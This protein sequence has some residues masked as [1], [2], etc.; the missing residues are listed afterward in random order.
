MPETAEPITRDRAS[1]RAAR[2]LLPAGAAALA[3]W[4]FPQKPLVASLWVLAAGAAAALWGRRELGRR[5]ALARSGALRQESIEDLCGV[6][7]WEW[8]LPG[9]RLRLSAEASR[10]L[11]GGAASESFPGLLALLPEEE[12]ETLSAAV[13]RALSGADRF[14]VQ[15]A[16]IPS[17]GVRR[18]I[19]HSGA[20]FRDAAGEPERLIG[21]LQDVTGRE[22][23]EGALFFE[24]RYRALIENLPQRIFLKDLNSVYLSCNSSFARDLGLEPAQVF[25]RTDHDLFPPQLAQK[26]LQDDARVLAAGVPE[27]RDELRERD[28]AWISKALIPLKDD[29]GRTYGLLGILTDVTSRKQA[30]EQLKESE[31]RFRNTFEQA[32]VGICHLTLK[33]G[34]IRINRRF[35]EILG[36]SQEELLGRVLD[37][38]IHPEDLAPEH[39]N[40]ERLLNREIDSYSME[41]RHLKKEGAPVWVNFSMSLV[42]NRAGEPRYFAAMIEDI[43]A[44]REAEAL[45][46]ERDLVQASSRAMSQLLANMSHEIRTPMNAVLGLGHLALKTELTPKQRDY[47]EKICSSSRNLLEI[48]NDILDFSKI[49]S[50]RIELEWTEFNLS[51]V[52]KTVSD[53]MAPRA[54]EKGI[55]YRVRVAPELPALVTGDPLRLAQVLNNLIANAV[56]FTEK[57]EVLVEVRPAGWQ[58]D[59]VA[60]RFS[61]QDTGVGLTPEQLE[62]IFTPFTQ[63][64]SSTT[65]RYGGTGLGLSI[66]SQL[67]ELMGGGLGVE[68]V[69]GTG[70][71]FSFTINFGLSG[72]A[73]APAQS[74]DPKLR[75]LK[76]LALESEPFPRERLVQAVHGLPFA[77]EFTGTAAQARAALERAALPGAQPVD[78]VVVSQASAGMDG[79]ELICREVAAWQSPRPP[80]LVT[81]ALESADK[82]RERAAELDI[83]VV[84]PLPARNS[85]LLD[86]IVRALAQEEERARPAEPAAPPPPEGTGDP[87]AQLPG[88]DLAQALKRLGGNR[89]LLV[90]LLK[91]FETDFTGVLEELK[92]ALARGENE[93]A[94]RLSHTLKGVAGNLSA[95]YVHAAALGLE[96]AIAGAEDTWHPLSRLSE[97]LEP[98]L[99]ALR[100]LPAETAPAPVTRSS[101]AQE[102]LAAEL[103]EL[104][105]LLSKNSLNAK[106]QFA[107]LRDGLPGEFKEELR[108]MES[109]MDKLDFKKART[110]L[111]RLTSKIATLAIPGRERL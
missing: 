57:G 70:S 17:D 36:Y 35:C 14:A 59:Q 109:C 9:G 50:G 4:L 8:E 60:V 56:K 10:I 100:T 52:L 45:R 13:T 105:R 82:L 1:L 49:E 6:G 74:D 37:E 65:R 107:K 21:V 18:L 42:R 16:L 93:P 96:R 38:I 94:R 99:A 34:L 51:Q 90:K 67:V 11:S 2:V 26:R 22:E 7:S 88:F 102:R 89:S 84:L 78:L 72:T 27:E 80:I 75:N 47:L 68:S 83:A 39:D 29:A 44:K 61:V 40:V 20:L 15:H 91:E 12:R 46:Q 101:V 85:L 30:E 31:E 24:K 97:V 98:F 23:A 48:I 77:V 53:M 41:L 54:Q 81:V 108:E 106:R 87:L 95:T 110:L 58:E 103:A 19:A 43:S 32:A 64:D 79:V 3:P 55:H 5:D 73:E 25:G 66:S 63:A 33:G 28:N 76:I 111:A 69:P 104:E 62:K 86:A 92:G 71:C